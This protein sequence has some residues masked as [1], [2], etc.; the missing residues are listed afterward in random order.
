MALEVERLPSAGET[1]GQMVVASER[2]WWTADQSRVVPDG[3]PDAA[4]LLCSP[5]DEI[6]LAVAQS[7]GA[8]GDSEAEAAPPPVKRAR[9]KKSG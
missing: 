3:H 8:T 6:P 7:V 4:F 9:A 5:G 1:G 2:L